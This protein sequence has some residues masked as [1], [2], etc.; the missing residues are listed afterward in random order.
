MPANVTIYGTVGV[1][2]V[3]TLNHK[4]NG[5]LNHFFYS[6][7][8]VCIELAVHCTKAGKLFEEQ[9]ACRCTSY[10][11]QQRYKGWSIVCKYIEWYR[12]S[13]MS[14]HFFG[15]CLWVHHSSIVWRLGLNSARQEVTSKSRFVLSLPTLFIT[16]HTQSRYLR[17]GAFP[18]TKFLYYSN[19]TDTSVWYS[20]HTGGGVFI[21]TYVLSLLGW[22]DVSL[23]HR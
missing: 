14:N 5:T 2:F 20:T 16:L 19:D 15:L 7:T 21:C 1:L 3:N 12:F 23:V 22:S 8:Y 6:Y 18:L 9:G 11:G 13:G 4:S 10:M 17:N